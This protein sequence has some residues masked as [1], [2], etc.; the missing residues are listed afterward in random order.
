MRDWLQ[1]RAAHSVA[2][3]W[4]ASEWMVWVISY[5]GLLFDLLIVPLLLWRKA[6]LMAFVLAMA[7]HVTNHWLFDIGVFP[8][9]SIATTALFFP[10]D[11]PRRFGARIR[12]LWMGPTKTKRAP[13]LNANQAAFKYQRVIAGCLSI[14]LSWQLLMPLRHFLYPGVVSWTEEGHRF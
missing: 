11:W 10:A 8:W 5:G 4:L 13:L 14:Y 1:E 7:F 3:A 9:L 2:S 6:R 12:K